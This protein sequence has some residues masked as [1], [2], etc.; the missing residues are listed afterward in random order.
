MNKPFTF[1]SLLLL[2][3]CS[4]V[5]TNTT[6]F[7]TLVTTF[8]TMS[9][10][11]SNATMFDSLP[12]S[13]DAFTGAD[14]DSHSETSA[15]SD[16]SSEDTSAPSTGE[17]ETSTGE[18][19]GPLPV[20]PSGCA[21]FVEVLPR[22]EFANTR[23]VVVDMTGCPR[24]EFATL[25]YQAVSPLFSSW[26]APIARRDCG[27]FGGNMSPAGAPGEGEDGVVLSMVGTDEATAVLLRLEV[28]GE[29]SDELILPDD[30]AGQTWEGQPG[31]P[32]VSLRRREDWS[33]VPV[34]EHVPGCD[35]I[36]LP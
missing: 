29:V 6:T 31:A 5:D 24:A 27:V 19:A 23:Y 10:P 8:S 18:Q 32:T 17:A 9:S 16:A 25:T 12:T 13:S 33:W 15:L 28:E 35:L 21:V 14:D 20:P 26:K 36:P 34:E 4:D 22:T 1:L 2:A 3:A 7:S 30:L 11:S